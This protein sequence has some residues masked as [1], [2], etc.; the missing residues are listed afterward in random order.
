[1]ASH[2]DVP[3]S[4]THGEGIESQ[5]AVTSEGAVVVL[6]SDVHTPMRPALVRGAEISDLAPDAVPAEFPGASFVQ[7]KQVVFS[8]ADGMQI[9][10]QLFLPPD[11]RPGEHR[12]AV[13]F[14]HGGSRRQMLLGFHFMDCLLYTS[15]CV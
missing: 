14:L 5:P 15:R 12:P 6:R 2:A 7:P 3:E 8:A 9:R 13:V 10:G 11:L 1:M 4:L